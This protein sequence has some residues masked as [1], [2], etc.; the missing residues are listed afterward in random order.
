MTLFNDST[1]FKYFAVN[2]AEL[3]IQ[4][5][6]LKFSNPKD[7]NDPIDCDLDKLT[8]KIDSISSEVEKEL[9]EV[10]VHYGQKT[11]GLELEAIDP[12]KLIS[13]YK[14]S[15]KE[16]L[17]ASKV[18]CFSKTPYS[19]P[20]WSH[21]A[22]DHKGI[23][24]IFNMNMDTPF[25]HIPENK[26]NQGPVTYESFKSSNYFESKKAAIEKLFFTKTPE[27]NYESE[28][29]YF[30]K[31]IDEFQVFKTGFLK[32]VIFGIRFDDSQVE[33]FIQFCKSHGFANLNFSR[34]YPENSKINLT[35]I[36]H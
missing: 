25:N 11:K 31:K 8:F 6:T 22:D 7:F 32:G 14:N 5:K 13:F 28:Y 35:R 19:I 33:T 16:K 36:S 26:L 15:Q 4:N 29:R 18:C 27:W 17:K 34:C 3:V 9:E 1:L 10:K 21:Y 30:S 23:C 24:M 12:Q 2:T 20:M